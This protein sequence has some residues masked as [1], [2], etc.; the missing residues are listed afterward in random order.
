MVCLERRRQETAYLD[1][2]KGLSSIATKDAAKRRRKNVARNGT[3]VR[4]GFGHGQDSILLGTTAQGD[5]EAT[6]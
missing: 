6:T 4:D 2:I 5:K 3:R 1:G